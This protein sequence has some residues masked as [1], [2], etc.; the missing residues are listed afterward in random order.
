MPTAASSPIS[1]TRRTIGSSPRSISSAASRT[2]TW[3]TGTGQRT[4][5]TDPLGEITSF[6]YNSRGQVKAITNP[7]GYTTSY[8]YDDSNGNLQATVTPLGEITTY[9]Y[10]S[11]NQQI[12]QQNPLGNVWIDELRPD[13]PAAEPNRSTG[14]HHQL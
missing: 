10:N 12:A 13:E 6:S 5:V 2:L 11:L 14:L 8:V 9:D 4:A 7:R 1:T 3:D